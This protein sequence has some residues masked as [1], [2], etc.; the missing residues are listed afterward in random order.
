MIDIEAV[1]D[2]IKVY[3]TFVYGDPVLERRDQVWERLRRSSTTR[4]RP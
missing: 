1:I 2:R 4:N 3:M